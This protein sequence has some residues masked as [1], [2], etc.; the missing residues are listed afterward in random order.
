MVHIDDLPILTAWLR[1][2]SNGTTEQVDEFLASLDRAEVELLDGVMSSLAR[3]LRAWCL[4]D[5]K[6]MR[7]ALAAA[8]M[9]AFEREFGVTA[10]GERDGAEHAPDSG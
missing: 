7:Y 10:G 3:A 5:D 6:L 2:Q 4:A 8:T 1:K 9:R